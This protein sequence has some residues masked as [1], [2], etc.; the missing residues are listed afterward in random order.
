MK[1]AGKIKSVVSSVK[2]HW[3]KPPKERYMSYKE[4]A[5]LSVGGIGVR[6]IVYCVSNMIIAVGNTLIGNTIGIDPGALY[7]IY[8]LSILSGFPLTAL[9]AK[10]IDNTRSMKGKYR[11]YILTMGIPTV[12]LGI[13]FVWMPYEHMSLTMKCI[14][15]LL[16]N[17]G[18]QFFYNFMVDAYESLINVLSP[19]TIERSDVLSIRCVVENLSPSIAGIFLPIAARLITNDNTLYDM[20][21]YRVLYPPMLLVGFLISLLVYVN[22]EE[23]IVQAKTHV[24]RIKFIDAL[25]AIAQNKYFWI[26]SLAGWIGF[27]ESSFNSI[28]GWMYKLSGRVLT[29]PVFADNRDIRQ[30]LVL[31]ESRRAVP[32]QKI[33]QKEDTRCN[34]SFQYRL[35]CADAPDGS[36]NGRPGNNMDAAHMHLRQPVH[37]FAWSSSQPEHPGGYKRLSAV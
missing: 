2:T 36:P 31:A 24:I 11:P 25:K 34:E 32:Y 22:V 27:L 10:M 15:V 28:L 17:V 21:I 4:I 35:Y 6:F 19:N 13:G 33:R 37:N 26:I 18:F 20:R 12:I 29:G 23:K 5:S 3:N 14:V 1:I 8:I 7:V 30:R 16:F 9:R